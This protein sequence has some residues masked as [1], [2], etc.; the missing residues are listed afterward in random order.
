V[1]VN[2]KFNYVL[3]Q[4]TGTHYEKARGLYFDKSW[5]PEAH[6]N[7]FGIVKAVPEQLLF[8]KKEIDDIK[9][10]FDG[11]Y[12]CP[13]DRIS[14]IQ[15]L[16]SKSVQ[17]DVP[18]EIQLDDMVIMQYQVYWGA[19]REGRI[20]KEGKEMFIVVP[21]DMLI[22]AI[23]GEKIIPLNGLCLVEPVIE[24]ASSVIIMEEKESAIKGKIAHLGCEVKNYLGLED[25]DDDFFKK[26]DYVYFRKTTNL[27][28]EYS[29]HQR[30]DKKYFKIHRRNLLARCPSN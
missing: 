28:V 22:L 19:L 18:I 12:N 25:S 16:T 29:I 9:S 24:K 30:L 27:P 7:Q 1:N 10:E 3:L 23:R 11:S 15:Y 5:H 2:I 17:Y 13:L 8:F 4:I 21:Y 26:D 20:L 14:E 6:T